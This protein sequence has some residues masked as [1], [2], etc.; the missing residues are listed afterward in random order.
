MRFDDFYKTVYKELSKKGFHITLTGVKKQ[1]LQHPFYPSIQ[2][3]TDYLTDLDIPNTVVR[4]NFEQLK[5]ALTEADVI[6][7]LKDEEGDNLLWIKEINNTTVI[8]SN[9]KSDSVDTFLSQW[10]GVALLLQIEKGESEDEFDYHNEIIKQNR[11]LYFIMSIGFIFI[12]AGYSLVHFSNPVTICSLIPKIGGLIFS[13]LLVA[14][15]L[16]F[17]IAVT[18]KLCSISTGNG[19]EKVTHSKMSSITRNIKLADL[20]IIYFTTTLIFQLTSDVALLAA[21]ALLCIPLIIISILYQ[22]FKLK[23]FCPLCLSVMF[24]LIFDILIYYFTGIY[25]ESLTKQISIP[26]LIKLLGIGLFIS[27]SW[28]TLKREIQKQHSLENYQYQYYRLLR[29]PEQIRSLVQCLPKEHI[30]HP[31][32]EI[33]LGDLNAQLIITEVMN[34]YCSPCG[35]SMKKIAQLLNI[36]ETGLQFQILFISKKSN[37]ERCNRIIKHLLAFAKEHDVQTTMTALLDWFKSMDYEE[38]AKQYPIITLLSE[39]ELNRYLNIGKELKISHTP[40]MFIKEKRMKAELGLKD[41]RYFI[42]D[43]LPLA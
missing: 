12:L 17:K 24:M 21:I 4:I 1:L 9:G 36:Y 2:S 30:G 29:S 6:V 33:R 26:D 18:E 5:D 11:N 25:T 22:T 23:V 13:I 42:E 20:G 28:F 16:G 15:E 8:Y 37:R 27:G 14:M 32:N 10:K 31:E 19:C 43:E 38:W 40:T 41:L 34:P 35:D 7:L 39:E 3:V